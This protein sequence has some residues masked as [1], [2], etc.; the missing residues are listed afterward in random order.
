[1]SHNFDEKSEE[2]E[3][4][5]GVICDLI[6]ENHVPVPSGKQRFNIPRPAK[7]GYIHESCTSSNMKREPINLS[8][9]HLKG[10]SDSMWD[11]CSL[12]Y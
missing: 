11:R 3:R 4:G 5:S 9:G 10:T 7:M 2:R 1:M 8:R 12:V 6:D